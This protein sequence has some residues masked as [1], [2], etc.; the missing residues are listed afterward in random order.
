MIAISESVNF[1]TCDYMENRNK[2]NLIKIIKSIIKK[3]NSRGLDILDVFADN[4]FQIEDLRNAILPSTLQLCATGEHVPKVE[5]TIRIVKDR[6][7]T[8]CH[9]LP[10]SS[11]PK[12]M[13]KGLVAHYVQWINA[14]PASGGVVG[15]YSPSYL[16][17]GKQNAGF[18]KRRI[19]FGSY[20]V[21]CFR[22]GQYTGQAI[23]PMHCS[24]RS[25]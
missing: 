20:A 3:Y 11:F 23:N 2:K 10:Y 9:S 4:E 13:S 16:M 7:R 21:V 6:C 14:F 17:E 24:H 8:I 12:L 1:L 25:K 22:I 19:T 15:P 5:R 18:N